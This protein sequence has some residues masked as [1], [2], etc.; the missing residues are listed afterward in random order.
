[1]SLDIHNPT[2]RTIRGDSIQ[3]GLITGDGIVGTGKRFPKF[4]V[5][6]DGRGLSLFPNVGTLFPEGWETLDFSVEFPE[7]TKGD[8]IFKWVFRV[9]NDI[10]FIDFPI[11]V[12]LDFA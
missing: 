12:K 2:S 10:A 6:P 11:T 3:I 1:M 7:S 4:I 8:A 5:L 9:F